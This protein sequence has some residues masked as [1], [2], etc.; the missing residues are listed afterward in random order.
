M[1][2]LTKKQNI[3]EADFLPPYGVPEVTMQGEVA[4][5]AGLIFAVGA[6][7]YLLGQN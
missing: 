7:I 5:V 3:F 4:K 2:N 1:N 6:V